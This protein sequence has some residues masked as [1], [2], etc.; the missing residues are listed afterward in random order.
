M[1]DLKNVKWKSLT[2]SDSISVMRLEIANVEVDN[3]ASCMRQT[4]FGENHV[5]AVISTWS[6]R[7]I[8]GDGV[9]DRLRVTNLKF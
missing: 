1:F 5:A 3:M 7:R 9:K 8:D 4:E 2:E 6:T